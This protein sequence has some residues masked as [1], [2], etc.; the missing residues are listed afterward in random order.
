MSR[1]KSLAANPFVR[2]AAVLADVAP[3]K[4]TALRIATVLGEVVR[5]FDG[6][7]AVNFPTVQDAGSNP[8]CFQPFLRFVPD[9]TLE[10]GAGGAGILAG[11]V[12]R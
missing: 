11:T 3:A 1:V 12:L 7:F 6:G 10:R 4:G 9:V 8:R 5:H 2:G